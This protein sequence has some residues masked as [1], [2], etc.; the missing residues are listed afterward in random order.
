MEDYRNLDGK[1][2]LKLCYPELAWG[3][4][5]KN[6]NEWY[7]TSNPFTNSTITGFQEIFLAF[8]INSNKYAWG[9]LGINT[10]GPNHYAIIDDS[11]TR[12][13]Y[14][15]AIG[16]KNYWPKDGLIPGPRH[17][18]IV[19]NIES[20]YTGITKVVLYVED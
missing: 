16:V 15:C 9:G 18:D 19:D 5:G 10:K 3:K 2:K 1:F 11:P 14:F 17:P 7:Q 13:N 20:T 4:N 6:C 12:D 8:H